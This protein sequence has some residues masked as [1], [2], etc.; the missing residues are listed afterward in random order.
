MNEDI[1]QLFPVTERYVYLNHAAAAPISLPVQRRMTEHLR[2]LVEAGHAHWREWG[3]ALDQVRHV[4]A[5][6]VNCAPSE[7]AFVANTSSGLSTI[8]NGITWQA[9]DNIVTADCEFPA[10]LVPW[11]RLERELGI[12]VRRA[13]EISCRID[14]SA[15]L[16]LVDSR[17]RVISLSFVEF[18]SGFRNDLATIGSFC[19][20][21]GILFVVDAIQGL[22][23]LKFDVVRD[24]VD[25][26]A[27]DAHKFLLGPEGA[28]I[29]YA[30]PRAM[31]MVRPTN[32]GW[33]SVE[34]PFSFGNASQA[35]APGARRFEAG[36]LNTTGVLGLGAAIE[37]FLK[38]GIEVIEEYL[39]DL[40]NYLVLRLDAK[41]YE[42]LSSRRPGE[43]S[44]IICC[45]H[46]ERAATALNAH[47]EEQG[48]ITTARL[49]RLRISPHFYN[50]RDDIDRLIDAL[51]E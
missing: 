50:T 46:P 41:G 36:T 44:A 45:R 2:D 14:A 43:A 25:A 29:L 38:T 27:A 33:T 22:G 42:V 51:P 20:E 16:D 24:H 10:N 9:G 8:A 12:E 32:V 15:L 28:A 40:T 11:L 3:E 37:L 30:G 6:F 21:R 13:T 34:N 5:S 48:I 19:K 35:Y 26:F 4:V 49:G 39:L 31:E 17:T 1:R 7:I 47:L 23:A 18:G